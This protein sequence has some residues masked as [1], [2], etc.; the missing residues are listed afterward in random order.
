MTANTVARFVEALNAG[1]LEALAECMTEGHVFTDSLGNRVE[2]KAAMIAGWRH[3]LT[4]FPDYRVRINDIM[5][6]DNEALAV[7]VAGGTLHR[8]GAPVAG[9]AWR[10]P[11][12]WR[13]LVKNDK[14]AEWQI[15][16]DNKPVYDLFG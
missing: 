13:A 5:T 10:I 9:G 4:M 1:D 7:G 12:A 8:D 15:Y 2:G 14:V 11:A 6:R 3:Y 16:A